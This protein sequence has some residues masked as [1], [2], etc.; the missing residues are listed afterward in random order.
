ML[1]LSPYRADIVPVGGCA[2]ISEIA[3]C[4]L[5]HPVNIT[6]DGLESMAPTLYSVLQLIR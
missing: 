4:L 1:V 5:A 3:G 6:N 2:N